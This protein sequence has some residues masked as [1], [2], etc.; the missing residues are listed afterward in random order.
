MKRL[1]FGLR[2]LTIVVLTAGCTQQPQQV[3][4][5]HEQ[6]EPDSAVMAQ[7]DFNMQMANAAD[8]L[9]SEWVKKDSATYVLDEFGFWYHK[10]IKQQTDSSL[11]QGENI[12]LHMLLAELNGQLLADVKDEFVVGGGN[13]PVSI[14]R[15]LKLMSRGE[16]MQ[17]VAPWYAAYGIEG[18]TLIK[19]Y[20]NLIITLKIEE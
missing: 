16:E 18:T 17:I 8:K 14:N 4:R 13:L 11:Q 19:P 20:T 10:T 3:R 5:L 1:V 6:Q 7:M 2:L 12:V 15:C 9:C